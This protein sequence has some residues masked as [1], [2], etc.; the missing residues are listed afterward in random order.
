MAEAEDGEDWALVRMLW[1]TDGG[2]ANL[3]K[4]TGKQLGN[5]Y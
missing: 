3:Y 5:I 1:G 2:S 4:H